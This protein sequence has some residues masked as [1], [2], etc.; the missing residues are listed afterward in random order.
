MD[1]Q[2]NVV[3][4]FF[5]DIILRCLPYFLPKVPDYVIKNYVPGYKAGDPIVCG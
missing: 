3:C 5:I 4:H 1:R 2:D